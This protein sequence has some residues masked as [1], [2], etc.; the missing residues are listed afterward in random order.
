MI[1]NITIDGIINN[2][3]IITIQ[4]HDTKT[5]TLRFVHGDWRMMR[6]AIEGL[7]LAPGV[8]VGVYINDDDAEVLCEPD[9][10]TPEEARL[11]TIAI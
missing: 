5:G 11:L 3:S 7:G 4:G 10:L 1:N 6:A 9:Y 8:E 2:G